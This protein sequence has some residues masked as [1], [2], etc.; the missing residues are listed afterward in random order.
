MTGENTSPPPPEPPITE[1]MLRHADDDP[2]RKLAIDRII[3]L[4]KELKKYDIRARCGMEVEFFVDSEPGKPVS[5]PT[6]KLE[7]VR[8]RLSQS[9][10]VE[11]LRQ[12]N[13]QR[14]WRQPAAMTAI[15]IVLGSIGSLITWNPLP[16][17][18]ATG[19]GAGGAAIY[20]SG[21]AE[22][23]RAGRLTKAA[24]YE[25][26]LGDTLAGTEKTNERT[27]EIRTQ[28]HRLGPLK[29]AI[30][31]EYF[32]KMLADILNDV[33]NVNYTAKPRNDN[34]T[35]AMHI[36]ISLTGKDGANLFAGPGG[37]E[38]KLM[39]AC[40]ANL[41]E[42]QNEGALMFLPRQN[43]HD[44]IHNGMSTPDTVGRQTSKMTYRNIVPSGT[45]DARS[46]GW[47]GQ[48]SGF[49]HGYRPSAKTN[50]IEGRMAG[51]DADPYLAVAA[52]LGAMVKTLKEQ[53]RGEAPTSARRYK[54]PRDLKE[55]VSRFERSSLMREILG[56]DLY[57]AVKTQ[58]A[59]HGAAAGISP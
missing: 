31:T 44:R 19:L 55:S 26:N 39:T 23:I 17:L 2:I 12:E 36:N 10:Y 20:S 11:D 58:Y 46:A 47:V 38:S 37:S 3:E 14:S 53:E 30:A 29:A 54:L 15:G 16:L 51:A 21:M 32:Q 48:V 8:K 7:E 50:R 4:E 13:V 40:I 28:R 6:E 25:I 57:E 49:L 52:T 42:V 43:S 41:V 59:A 33:G 9:R 18:V 35:S 1:L 22:N 24:Q 56:N 27:G 45:A 34:L 5:I